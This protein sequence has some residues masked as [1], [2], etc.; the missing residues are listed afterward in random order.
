MDDNSKSRSKL[1]NHARNNYGVIYIYNIYR[2]VDLNNDKKKKKKYRSF[3]RRVTN[4]CFPLILSFSLP[5]YV[6]R[7]EYVFNEAGQR[8][9][10]VFFFIPPF[11]FSPP[12]H[13]YVLFESLGKFSILVVDYFGEKKKK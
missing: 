3:S 4:P 11:F 6:S 12:F 9:G 8:E 7:I 2:C 5:F 13:Y 10:D 1:L